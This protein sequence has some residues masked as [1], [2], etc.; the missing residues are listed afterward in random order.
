MYDDPDGSGVIDEGVDRLLH[1]RETLPEGTSDIGEMLER[2]DVVVLDEVLHVAGPPRPAIPTNAA[3]GVSA[4]PSVFSER[5][6]SVVPDAGDHHDISLQEAGSVSTCKVACST[7][8]RVLSTVRADPEHRG[9]VDVAA[10][11]QVRRRDI[12]A[13]RER[14]AA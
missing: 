11:D 9:G 7:P 8:N 12:H 14:G 13:R 6:N 4:R 2:R 3:F 1:H 10:C 5:T